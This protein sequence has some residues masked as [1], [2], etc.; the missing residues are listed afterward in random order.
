MEMVEEEMNG[1]GV[2]EEGELAEEMK[3]ERFSQVVNWVRSNA[4]CVALN[5]APG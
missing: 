2:K 1:G 4:L 3:M 5:L